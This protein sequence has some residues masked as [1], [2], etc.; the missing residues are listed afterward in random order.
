MH[1]QKKCIMTSFAVNTDDDS[2]DGGGF[3]RPHTSAGTDREEA[4]L[5][6]NTIQKILECFCKQ[7]ILAQGE[8][9][10]VGWAT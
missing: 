2:N 5:Q 7:N 4:S 6:A 9:N 8:L 10:S 1:T 3:R